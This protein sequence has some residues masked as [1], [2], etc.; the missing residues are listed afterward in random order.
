MMR[1]GT[2]FASTTALDPVDESRPR[3]FV[4]YSQNRA[5]CTLRIVD[6]L[7]LVTLIDG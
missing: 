4:S 5:V 1:L 2:A 6:V 7:T 3:V